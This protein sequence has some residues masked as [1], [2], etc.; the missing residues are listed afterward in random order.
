MPVPFAPALPPVSR[1]HLL[2]KLLVFC[3]SLGGHSFHIGVVSCDK[4]WLAITSDI[5]SGPKKQF[6][7]KVYWNNSNDFGVKQ[8][9][10]SPVIMHSIYNHQLGPPLFSQ[11]SGGAGG[12]HPVTFLLRTAIALWW[13]VFLSF[14]EYLMVSILCEVFSLNR[15]LTTTKGELSND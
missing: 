7:S 8:P 10:G 9:Q 11:A 12:C 6:I 5:Q 13:R 4:P 2:S 15:N 14:G 3:Q 1:N